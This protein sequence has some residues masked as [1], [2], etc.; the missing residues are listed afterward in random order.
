MTGVPKETLCLNWAAFFP[1]NVDSALCGIKHFVVRQ[2]G[3]LHDGRASDKLTK[4]V[5]LQSI[6]ERP[7][8]TIQSIKGTFELAIKSARSDTLWFFLWGFVKS[9]VYV[10]NK[11]IISELKRIIQ[12][13]IDESYAKKWSII[14]LEKY[15]F[16]MRRGRH[17]SAMFAV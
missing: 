7:R 13:F 11:G 1:C 14:L 5:W 2:Y 9:K 8:E 6:T 17:S 10:G 4:Q 12:K 16:Q 3:A 15:L